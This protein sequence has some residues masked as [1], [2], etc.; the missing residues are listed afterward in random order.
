[1][2]KINLILTASLLPLLIAGCATTSTSITN[3]TPQVESRNANG[4]YPVEAEL[5]TRQQSLRWETIQPSVLVGTESFP[6]RP[7]PL[8][9]NRWETLIPMPPGQHSV[10]YRIRFD[11][12]VNTFGPPKAESTVSKPFRLQVTEQ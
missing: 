6:M 11:Y 3:L 8:M 2:R 5:N 1:M 9:T 4:L 12:A 10:I 7:T